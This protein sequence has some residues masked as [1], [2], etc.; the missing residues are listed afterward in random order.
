MSFNIVKT[1][2]DKFKNIHSICK[3][4][5]LIT[6]LTLQFYSSKMI[7]G[8]KMIPLI[9][10]YVKECYRLNNVLKSHL[11]IPFFSDKS[12]SGII[13]NNLLFFLKETFLLMIYNNV[14]ASLAGTS[15]NFKKNI[16]FT[17]FS[18]ST[19]LNLYNLSSETV[20]FYSSFL[21]FKEIL[22]LNYTMFY[23]LFNEYLSIYYQVVNYYLIR[24][25]NDFIYIS[26]SNLGNIYN[27]YFFIILMLLLDIMEFN[28]YSE[29]GSRANSMNNSI[30]NAKENVKYF[31]LVYNRYRQ[32]RITNEIIEII[33][34]SNF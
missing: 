33:S 12:C 20:N 9:F 24:S 3:T 23:L 14:L 22:L 1:Q 4:I 16:F 2:L 6:I 18:E 31:S 27:V 26:F 25:L 21:V 32:A 34:S 8:I 11:V 29:L 28:M 7:H 10:C 30:V 19:I 5:E 15:L 17:S 13:N